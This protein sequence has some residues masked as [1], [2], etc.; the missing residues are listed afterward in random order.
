MFECMN[1]EVCT[2]FECVCLCVRVCKRFYRSLSV[3]VLTYSLPA[4]TTVLFGLSVQ[5]LSTSR[6]PAEEV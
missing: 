3:S 2:Y 6:S 1:I 5:P 4:A